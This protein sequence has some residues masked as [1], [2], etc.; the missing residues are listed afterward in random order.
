[1]SQAADVTF[2]IQVE[3][4]RTACAGAAA[5]YLLRRMAARAGCYAPGIQEHIFRSLEIDRHGGSIEA[6]QRWFAS[7]NDELARQGYRVMARRVA[8]RTPGIC[9]WV[10]AG[11]GFRGAVLPV[12]GKRLRPEIDFG[13]PH[14]VALTMEP[15]NGAGR[16]DLVLVDP[17]PGV[18]RRS[19]PPPALEGAHR[20]RNFASLVLYW[21][22]YS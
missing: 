4:T 8:F 10:A 2:D 15:K 18:E 12:D 14:A 9:D 3:S 11:G 1:M 7:N 13:G 16:D 19:A 5:A 22:G 21:A 20:L 6:V 17:W